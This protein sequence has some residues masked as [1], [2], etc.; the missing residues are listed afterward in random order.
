MGNGTEI[1]SHKQMKALRV[2]LNTGRMTMKDLVTLGND[3]TKKGASVFC[4][5]TSDLEGAREKGDVL[6]TVRLNGSTDPELIRIPLTWIPIDLTS[7]VPI[8]ALLTSVE[9][10][11]AINS[12]TVT[13]INE[14][15]ANA[16]LATRMGREEQQS[17]SLR[18]AFVDED[19]LR[20]MVKNGGA[21]SELAQKI[22]AERKKSLA[23]DA[24]S[25]EEGV[26]PQL[27]SIVNRA[28]LDTRSMQAA[29]T[30]ISE[31]LTLK[32]LH[33]IIATVSSKKHEPIIQWANQTLEDFDDE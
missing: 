18:G 13:L 26:T 1:S 19:S 10:R 7:F 25:P 22:L 3:A 15:T 32:D 11:K 16:I 27:V 21:A 8:E 20:N 31:K 12:G 9:L 33:Y 5:N 2:Q 28:D 4:I 29:I 14:E 24:S 23:K 6:M 30:A 17:I